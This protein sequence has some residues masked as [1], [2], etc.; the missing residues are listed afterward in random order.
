[1]Q[2]HWQTLA[3]SLGALEPRPR[4]RATQFKPHSVSTNLWTTESIKDAVKSG[5]CLPCH[6]VLRTHSGRS[7]FNLSKLNMMAVLESLSVSV[8]GLVLF[9]NSPIVR[10]GPC[11]STHVHRS[12]ELTAIAH[13]GCMVKVEVSSCSWWCIWVTCKPCSAVKIGHV[14][15]F[16]GC[17][18]DEAGELMGVGGIGLFP[19]EREWIAEF[20]FA[21]SN[22][23]YGAKLGAG[24]GG[25]LF[26]SGTEGVVGSENSVF[27]S[28][29]GK[30]VGCGACCPPFGLL[31]EKW[32]CLWWFGCMF[33]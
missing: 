33:P 24:M 23:S 6:A 1:M 8:S 20:K 3:H 21:W 28:F 27:C 13:G 26:G 16:W 5:I 4:A 7:S 22:S 30:G 12:E 10:N 9:L 29:C 15:L 19:K 25:W 2:C 18:V 11:L 31:G 17:S 32:F 14:S